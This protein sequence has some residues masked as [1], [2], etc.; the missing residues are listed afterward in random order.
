MNVPNTPVGL[1]PLQTPAQPNQQWTFQQQTDGSFEIHS[2][3]NTT[4]NQILTLD[5][6]GG[7]DADNTNCI[8]WTENDQPNQKWLLTPIG[9]TGTFLIQTSMP[10]NR[11]IDAYNNQNTDSWINVN[12]YSQNNNTNQQWTIT[13]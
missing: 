8:V 11:N 10:S 12:L 3:M 6:S 5:A 1:Y 9:T 4:D 13:Y 7:V 2:A